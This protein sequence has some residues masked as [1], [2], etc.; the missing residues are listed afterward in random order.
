MSRRAIPFLVVVLSSC[1]AMPEHA[2]NG[3][4]CAAPVPPTPKADDSVP[5]SA[6]RLLQHRK[7]QKELKLSAEQRIRIVDELA[8]LDDEHEKKINE[9]VR[10]PN[11]NEEEFDKLSKEYQKKTD[12][13]LA[14]TAAK[15]LTAP[16]RGR[17]RQLDLWVRGPTAFADPAVAKALA[18]TDAQ[19][20]KAVE[21]AEQMKEEIERFIDGAGDDNDDKRK[22]RLFEFRKTQLKELEATLTADQKT[23]WGTLLGPAPTGFAVDELWLKIEE[24]M[25]LLAP[26][27][28]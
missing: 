23:T 3:R 21:V 5:A 10:M 15:A 25:D 4:A 13:V 18:L 20:K 27:P 14:E 9:L 22:A 28:G 16:Q 17:L 1:W 2:W 8:D 26:P 7:V 12:K 24:E 11:F 19:K 6:S